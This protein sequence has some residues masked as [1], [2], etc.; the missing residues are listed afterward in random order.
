[1]TRAAELAA[2]GVRYGSLSLEFALL[3]VRETHQLNARLETLAFAGNVGLWFVKGILASVGIDKMQSSEIMHTLQEGLSDML[4]AQIPGLTERKREK[5]KVSD[6]D[7]AK[8]AAVLA[9]RGAYGSLDEIVESMKKLNE[10][11]AGAAEG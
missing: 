11:I 3:R 7:K 4:S 1:M 10:S 6:E 8:Y 5:R 2:S 9:A